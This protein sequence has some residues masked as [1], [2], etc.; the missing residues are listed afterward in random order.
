MKDSDLFLL[1]GIL[2]FKIGTSQL[3]HEKNWPEREQC[4]TELEQ[5]RQDLNQ[6]IEA[7]AT[8]AK[9]GE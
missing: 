9:A 3:E 4:R 5:L 7:L 6:Y 2:N 8:I 1:N